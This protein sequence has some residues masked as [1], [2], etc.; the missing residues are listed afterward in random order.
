MSPTTN[1]DAAALASKAADLAVRSDYWSGFGKAET[2]E[3]VS[4]FDVP[5]TAPTSR[6]PARRTRC[7][8]AARPRPRRSP[9]KSLR[10]FAESG[11]DPAVNGLLSTVRT[12]RLSG[13]RLAFLIS[14]A[15]T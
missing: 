10:R 14:P 13:R 3:F 2:V 4:A 7:T 9:E 1:L 12:R 6:S 5:K 15:W 11:S 8:T